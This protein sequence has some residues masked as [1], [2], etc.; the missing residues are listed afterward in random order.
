MKTVIVIATVLGLASGA[1]LALADGG[2]GGGG[3]GGGDG[4]GG[5]SEWTSAGKDYGRAVDL[6]ETGNYITAIPLLKGILETNPDSA[7]A[8]NY[9]AYTHRKLGKFEPALMYYRKA[10]A[11]E[12]AHLGANEYLGELYLQMGD[13]AKAEERLAVLDDACFFGCE[14][15]YALEEAIA[16]YKQNGESGG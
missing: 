1:G 14:S 5:P 3:G 11:L 7:D 4:R 13:L 10:L 9:L 15:Y 6:I 8:Y 2:G 16:A 12:P